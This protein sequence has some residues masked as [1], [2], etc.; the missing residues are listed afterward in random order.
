VHPESSG[1][2]KRPDFLVATRGA[3]RFYLEAIVATG[4]DQGARATDTRIDDFYNEINR[5]VSPDFFV[6]ARHCNFKPATPIP[7]AKVKRRIE[8]WLNTLDYEAVLALA[9]SGSIEG[10]PTFQVEHAGARAELTAIPKKREARGRTNVR[11]VGGHTSDFFWLNVHEDMKT[12]IKKKQ[13]SKYELGDLPY[14]IAVCCQAGHTRPR[15]IE[16]AL[17]GRRRNEEAGD[18]A[19]MMVA[20][21]EEG[22]WAGR[23]GPRNT[24]ISGVLA[25]TSL[26]PW[27]VHATELW[28]YHH[29]CAKRP[30]NCNELCMKEAV[31]APEGVKYTQPND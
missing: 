24:S 16:R 2:T 9:A 25:V 3:T 29:P 27:S 28:L 18:L 13:P 14:V 19:A 21:L 6:I 10:L 20:D 26:H 4:A 12:A 22:A 23:A 30:V 17:F 11:P 7:V 5:I 1:S 8:R 15:D 31:L